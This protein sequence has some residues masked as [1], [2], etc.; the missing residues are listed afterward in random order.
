LA[1]EVAPQQFQS[2]IS[3]SATS[4]FASTDLHCT[5]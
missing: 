1:A 2:A 3:R 5:S 4:S